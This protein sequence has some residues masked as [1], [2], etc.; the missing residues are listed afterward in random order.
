MF[1]FQVKDVS[2]PSGQFFIT[3]PLTAGE[4]FVLKNL[5]NVRI[6][7]RITTQRLCPLLI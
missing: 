2:I 7:P 6:L 3:V 1:N 5:A 4:M